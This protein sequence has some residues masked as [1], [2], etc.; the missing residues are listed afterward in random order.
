MTL[1]ASKVLEDLKKNMLVD[2]FPIVMDLKKSKGN[3]IVDAASGNEYKDFFSCFA[4][5]PLSYNHPMLHEKDFQ[6]KLLTAATNKITNSDIYSVEFAEGVKKFRETA[7]PDYLPHLFFVSGG[8]LAVENAMKTAFD[9]K[10][11]KNWSRGVSKDKELGMKI[12]HFRE[13]FHGRSGYTLSV[14]NTDPVKVQYFPKFDWPRVDNPKI[15]FPLEDNLNEVIKAEEKSIEQINQALKDNP[16]DIAGI[17]IEPIQGEGG[18][19]HFREEFLAKLKEICLENDILLIF[20]EVQTGIGITGKMWAHQHY[21]VEPDILS[22]GKKTQ[23]CGIL[24]GERIDEVKDNVFQKSSRINSTWGGNIVDIVRFS[25]Y[26]E[27]IEKENLVE[28]AR[29]QGEFILSELQKLQEDF[30][31]LIS[32]ARGK[33]LFAAVDFPT[34][35]LRDKF[36][37][38]LFEKGYI[39]LPAGHLAIRFR[40]LLDVTKE[41][42]ED[43]LGVWRKILK[44]F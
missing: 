41:Q 12:L 5:V 30:P 32:N 27:I 33:G 17:L 24:A 7:I 25:R 34:S 20:D 44:E 15:K 29:V 16:D 6:E 35:E 37:V 14:T 3:T 4:S 18:D 11:R 10:V 26:L 38:A 22:F 36:R 19:N 39:F 43:C 1:K 13:A 9:W 2:G 28:N 8:A 21:N 23:I 42:I 31:K 40:P